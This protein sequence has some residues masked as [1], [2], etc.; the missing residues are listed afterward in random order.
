MIHD[1]HSNHMHNIEDQLSIVDKAQSL[2]TAWKGETILDLHNED[3][4]EPAPMQPN[5]SNGTD[6]WSREGSER[7]RYHVSPRTHVY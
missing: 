2:P 4:V 3:Q 1:S 5:L 7:R 6:Y